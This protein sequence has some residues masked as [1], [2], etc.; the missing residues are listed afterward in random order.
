[1][2]KTFVSLLSGQAS[3]V[4]YIGIELNHVST[5]CDAHVL[6]KLY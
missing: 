4:E 3:Y 5:Q 6:E 2:F 1:M